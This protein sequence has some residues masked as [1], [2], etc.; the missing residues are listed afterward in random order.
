MRVPNL[1]INNKTYSGVNEVH[2]P[3]AN[4]SGNEDFDY[5]ITTL[6]EAIK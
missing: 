4:G 3:L 2:I 6:K 1:K 5:I